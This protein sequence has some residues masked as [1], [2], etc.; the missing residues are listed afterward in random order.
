MIVGQILKPQGIRGELKVKPMT[1]DPSR[2]CV[3]GSVRIKDAM[4]KITKARI[5]GG[6]VYIT[7][8]GVTD[9]NGAELFRGAFIE[10]D[11]ENAVKL[12]KGEF[13]ISDLIGCA[14]V[15]AYAEEKSN[16]G[17]IERI[18]SFGAADV[19]T[20]KT[21]RGGMSFAFIKALNAEYEAETR[22]L[23]VDGRALDTVVVYDD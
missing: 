8:D 2:F 14:L 9:R 15:A 20:V 1:S 3:L 4:Y 5:D 7:L 22:T 18:E 17:T 11:R 19:F 13:F 12:E 21:E 23:T 6:D 10:I 16:V